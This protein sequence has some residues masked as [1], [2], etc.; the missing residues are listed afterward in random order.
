MSLARGTVTEEGEHIVQGT[1]VRLQ[2]N[3]QR[4][5]LEV[6]V[7]KDSPDVQKI[8]FSE[9]A[10]DDVYATT[11][12]KLAVSSGEAVDFRTGARDTTITVATAVARSFGEA[13][14]LGIAKN[15]AAAAAGLTESLGESGTI[16]ARG[17]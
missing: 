7:Q 14:H 11:E 2:M 10:G 13:R 12:S 3:A 5:V 15:S 17:A 9:M 16:T 1:F 4:E 8:A 6:H